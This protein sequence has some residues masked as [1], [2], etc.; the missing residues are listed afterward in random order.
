MQ[1]LP[2]GQAVTGYDPLTAPSISLPRA[3][4]LQIPSLRGEYAGSARDLLARD[5]RDLRNYTNA[6]NSSLQELINLN[7]QMYPGVCLK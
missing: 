6:L 3:E 7:K 1:K 4:H 5:I 2:A